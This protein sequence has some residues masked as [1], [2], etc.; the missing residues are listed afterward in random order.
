[1]ELHVPIPM[2]VKIAGTTLTLESV[3]KF[4]VLTATGM[5][6]NISIP[7]KGATENLAVPFYIGEVKMSLKMMIK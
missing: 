5:T 4:T 7:E 3:F 2:K 6:A 1:M